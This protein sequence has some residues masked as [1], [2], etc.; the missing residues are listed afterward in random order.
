MASTLKINH[1]SMSVSCGDRSPAFCA[2]VLGDRSVFKSN[3]VRAP[4]IDKTQV[5]PTRRR[6]GLLSPDLHVPHHPAGAV[7]S[8]FAGSTSDEH[9]RTNINS[10][11]STVL[12]A[13]RGCDDGRCRL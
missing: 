5:G 9:V 8:V 13:D 10:A 1:V 6:R 2:D 11:D 12:L 4:K 3:M 7:D